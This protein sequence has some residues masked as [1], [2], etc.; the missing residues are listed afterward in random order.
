MKGLFYSCYACV[1]L[2]TGFNGFSQSQNSLMASVNDGDLWVMK[3]DYSWSNGWR[4]STKIL[5]KQWPVKLH[6]TGQK[7]EKIALMR[8][9]VVEEIYTPDILNYPIYFTDN[10]SRLT[11]HN[12]VL[13]Y[14]VKASS[15]A[16]AIKYVLSTDKSKLT[17]LTDM[18]KAEKEMLNYLE[19]EKK[20]QADAKDELITNIEN[21]REH[22]KELNS[23][24]GKNIV[25]IEL[26]WLTDESKTGLQSKIDYGIK[27]YDDKGKV[28][29]T[30]TLGGKMPWDDFNVTSSGAEPGYEFLQ[31]PANCKG[32]SNDHVTISVS[33]KYNSSLKTSGSIK[34]HYATPVYVDYSGKTCGVSNGST[35]SMGGQGG[36][37]LTIYVTESPDKSLYLLEIK[38]GVGNSLHKL[39]VKKGVTVGVSSRGGNGCSGSS[40]RYPGHGG[41]GG[42]ITIVHSPGTDVSFLSISNNGGKAGGAGANSG[43]NGSRNETTQSVNLNF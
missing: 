4:S 26:V 28:Y 30:N 20:K 12:G 16:K 7:I 29:M 10:T 8:G 22:E 39:K 37:N 17:A 1:F 25:R 24:R 34:L 42:N 23:I 15:D 13:F 32:L 27:A 35:R 9:G 2:L 18:D 21:E 19:E 33:S 11:F 43:K 41:D 36:V 6:R 3:V 38:D 5:E 14:Y 31:V 40:D